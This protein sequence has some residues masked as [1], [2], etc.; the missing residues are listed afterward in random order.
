MFTKK[1]GIFKLFDAEAI[2]S[3]LFQK[4][5]KKKELSDWRDEYMEAIYLSNPRQQHPQVQ[6]LGRLKPGCD[7]Q[8]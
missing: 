2:T 6:G 4:N 3:Y 7:P 1:C 8:C 5:K